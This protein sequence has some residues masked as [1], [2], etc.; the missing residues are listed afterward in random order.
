[1]VDLGR[2]QVDWTY[3]RWGRFVSCTFCWILGVFGLGIVGLGI[4]DEWVFL[5]FG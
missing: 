4:F 2:W 5:W 3:S 1:M